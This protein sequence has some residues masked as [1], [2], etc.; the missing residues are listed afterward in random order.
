MINTNEIKSFI[1]GYLSSGGRPGE[2]ALK[3][4]ALY[5]MRGDADTSPIDYWPVD[6][7][8]DVTALANNIA[9]SV[10]RDAKAFGGMQMYILAAYFGDA[11]M[12]PGTYGARLPISVRSKPAFDDKFEDSPHA[13]ST[14]DANPRGFAAQAFRW[15]E[16]LSRVALPAIEGFMDRQAEENNALRNYV[17][18]LEQQIKDWHKREQELLDKQ[19]ERNLELRKVVF[20]ERQKEQIGKAVIGVLSF[21]AA[22]YF[23]PKSGGGPVSDPLIAQLVD[24]IE[25]EQLPKIMSAFSQ[26]Q[27]MVLMKLFNRHLSKQE[28]EEKAEADRQADMDRRISEVKAPPKGLPDAPSTNPMEPLPK[29]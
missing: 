14:E 8:T 3:V 16:G 15:A 21:M 6:A 29:L 18:D 4:L 12:E 9:T 26:P 13:M 10:N 17:R 24:S 19:H 2:G 1:N 5:H 7:T 11:R 22:S 23:G 27:Q 28:G 20:W 25:P